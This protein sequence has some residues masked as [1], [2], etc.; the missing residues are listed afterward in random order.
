MLDS[1]LE[2]IERE[3]SVTQI[4][5]SIIFK[6]HTGWTEVE[7]DVKINYDLEYS[8]LEIKT[9]QLAVT[10]KWMFGFSTSQGHTMQEESPCIS[11]LLHSTGSIGATHPTLTFQ[12]NSHLDQKR[13]G[14]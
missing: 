1:K 8:P 4:T 13:Y 10:R 6:Q 12:L 9:V 3:T 5:I 11:R 7:R 2:E 14:R